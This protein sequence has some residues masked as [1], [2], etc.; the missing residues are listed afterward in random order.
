MSGTELRQAYLFQG[1]SDPELR[2]VASSARERTVA[3][4][5]V[6]Y[7]KGDKGAEF[8]VIAEGRVE[9]IVG[10][11]GNFTC[12]AGQ[13]SAGGHFGEVSLLTGRPR[14]LTV[15]ALAPTRL[16]VF[17]EDQFHST[18]LADPRIHGTLDKALAERLFLA[19]D[20]WSDPNDKS[21][22]LRGASPLAPLPGQTSGRPDGFPDE[23][24]EN[25][26]DDRQEDFEL[27]RKIRKE[28]VRFAALD[29]PVLISGEPG[30]GRR[31]VARQIHLQSARR[32]QPF[33]ELDLREF[34]AWVWEEKLF[35]YKQDSF[36]FS[37]GRQLG[38]L[39]QV[40]GGTLVL[41]HG[42][43]LSRELQE[44]LSEACGR[45]DS[46]GNVLNARLIFILDGDPAALEQ[47]SVFIP[48]LTA[49]L[50]DQH[51]ILPPL[52]E[53]K[54]DILPLVHFYLKRCNAELNKKVTGISADALGMLMKYDWPGNLTELSNVVQRAVMVSSG[55]EI[56]AEQIFLGQSGREGRLSFNLLRLPAVRRL[57]QGKLQ[58]RLSRVVLVLFSLI[59]LILFFG[60]RDA[61]KNL[62][63]TLCWYIG[64]P[65][66]IIS[67][68]FL[69][70][71]WCSICALSAPGKL[72]QKH[73]QPS[74]RLPA[75]AAAHSG[76]IMALFCLTVFWAEIVFNAYD[77]PRL[78]GM[79]LLAI[80]LGALLFSLLFERYSWCRY[81][82]PLGALNAVFS[83]P[84][85]LE[86][87]ANREMCVNQCRDHACFRGTATSP[88]C[89][90]FRHPFMVD[91]NR[92]CILCGR[93]I[94][95]CKLRSIELNLR[96]APRELWSLR[97]ARLADNFLIV[98]LG[99]VYFILA[100]HTRFL[101]QVRLWSDALAVGST[102]AFVTSGTL[103]FWGMLLIG[104][105]G[106]LVVS[107]FQ[108]LALAE[109]R[110]KVALVSGYGLLPL[111]LGGFLAYYSK[112]FIQEAWRLIPNFLHLFGVRTGL[113]QFHF[114][115]PAATTTLLHII[116]LG[117]MGASLYA[118]CKIFSR[119]LGPRLTP[120]RL[121]LPCLVVA[122]LGFAFLAVI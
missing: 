99:A 121:I 30:T 13:I 41:F 77:N 93:C 54:G 37:S 88:G 104:W 98:S 61:E 106:Y 43:K 62:G 24:K 103:L 29:C 90:M 56:V 45:E 105:A 39:E 42:E 22:S 18:L 15:R 47:K 55:A 38:I 59:L 110:R 25:G 118:T 58:A 81:A 51:F 113:G 44:K 83:M 50:R 48:E 86:L 115:S 114:L 102:A 6:V 40:R 36:P 85:I 10:T 63:I 3:A 68:F 82:C 120:S 7:H 17:D 100:D 67:F 84:S 97:N 60:P 16:L 71:F 19:S 78:T 1:L 101:E 76:W 46:A 108:A 87:R 14:S 107:C 33:I 72:L 31:L 53:H 122:I 27:A 52:R 5:E 96:L 70:R 79:I 8:Y 66:L 12:I 69:P 74:R 9:L 2:S 80:A 34:E 4:G 11:H 32:N 95:N 111:V 57:F 73:F 116:I 75:W 117:G 64:W 112:L 35:G 91:N 92:D 28:I 109:E 89:P 94:R 49:L 23:E 21:A 26:Q 119:L 20:G 65:L